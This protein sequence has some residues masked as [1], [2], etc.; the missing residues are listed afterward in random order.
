[1]V[2]DEFSELADRLLHPVSILTAFTLATVAE[3]GSPFVS[4]G[5][6]L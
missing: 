3:D 1:M 4:I 2:I 5:S 6:S